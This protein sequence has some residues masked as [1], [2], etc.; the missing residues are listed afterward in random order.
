MHSIDLTSKQHVTH[1]LTAMIDSHM[2]KSQALLIPYALINCCGICKNYWFLGNSCCHERPKSVSRA[3]RNNHCETLLGLSTVSAKYPK[4]FKRK[5]ATT[6]IL[7]LED[8]GLID[9]YSQS[10]AP[11]FPLGGGQLPTAKVTALPIHFLCGSGIGTSL[12]GS[13]AN[14]NTA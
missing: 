2:D 5:H 12:F 4:I 13:N 11:D 9:L 3:V 8:M 6:L 1:E 14:P 7:T 10:G